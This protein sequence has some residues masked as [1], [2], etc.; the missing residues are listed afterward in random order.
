MPAPPSADVTALL[1]DWSNGNEDA[2]AE[3]MPAVY[4][5][6]HRLAARYLRRE[7]SGHTL[8]TTALVHEAYLRLVDQS[9]VEWKNSLHFYGLAASMMR[10]I[11][12]DHAREHGTDKRGGQVHKVS[13]D[14]VPEVSLERASEVI[15]VDEAL[16]ALNEIDPQMAKIVELRFFGGFGNNEVAEFLNISVPTVVRRWRTAK[17]WLYRHLTRADGDDEA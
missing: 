2:A 4:G 3:L 14:Q 9:R 15:A 7:R 13:L 12:V 17:A 11:L 1:V 6:L 10:R 16:A 8:Q 5:E